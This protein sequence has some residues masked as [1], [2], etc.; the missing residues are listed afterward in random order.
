M[1]LTEDQFILV[2]LLIK[3]G[4]MAS[5]ATILIRS[6]RFKRLLFEQ[7]GARER[8]G[9]AMVLGI[10]L[11]MGVMMRLTIHYNA[12][13]LSLS[14]TFLVG[15]LTGPLTGGVVGCMVGLSAALGGEF[16]AVPM[17]VLYGLV[18]G[19]IYMV[20]PSREEIWNF[21]PLTDMNLYRFFKTGILSRKLDWKIV[22]FAAC[23][24]LEVLRI[25]ISKR[26]GQGLVFSLA[27]ESPF[28]LVCV[29][30][31]TISCL[32]IPLKIWNN[33][34]VEILLKEQ[35]ALVMRARFDALKRQINPHF[36]FNT[37]NSIASLVRLD[38]EKARQM[39]LKL[40][41]ILRRLLES[42]RDLI[43]L[44]EEMDFI[45]AYLDIEVIRFGQDKLKID[46]QIDPEVLDVL[47]PAMVLQPIVE[48]AIK[49]GI[50]SKVEGGTIRISAFKEDE[51]VAIE[52]EDDGQGISGNR[53][54][55]IL[56]QGIG[57]RNVN[58]RLKVMFGAD[59]QLKLRSQPGKGTCARIEL[60]YSVSKI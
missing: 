36:L 17:G 35:E 32:G 50:T 56:D 28:V 47:V 34:R 59:H 48:N 44:R 12:V 29:L 5:L 10:L 60:P 18:S 33:T 13:D 11:S 51:Q 31:S 2:T 19:A 4:V 20:C 55:G 53:L 7:K 38:P 14:G 30:I 22:F 26:S 27:P 9:F 40:S 3:V 15:L 6:G 46:K 41:N 39:V 8:W 16:L 52:I 1:I 37:L 23:M 43:S 25:L 54:H 49:H 45:E 42:D 58:E 24:S 57:I 21:S